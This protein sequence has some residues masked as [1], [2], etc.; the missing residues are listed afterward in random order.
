MP[1]L[2]EREELGRD[3]RSEVS[4][5]G[6]ITTILKFSAT[7]VKAK[8]HRVYGG[9]KMHFRKTTF[10][11]LTNCFVKILPEQKN[12]IKKNF[13]RQK[14]DVFRRVTMEYYERINYEFR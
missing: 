3:K 8:E 13:N 10:C 5:Y 1:G 2:L 14:R 12:I 9:T 4:N 6:H 7:S 11:E